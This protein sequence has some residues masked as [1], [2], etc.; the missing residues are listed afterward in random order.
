MNIEHIF[1][2]DSLT[3][4]ESLVMDSFHIRFIQSL[5]KGFMVLSFAT[6]QLLSARGDSTWGIKPNLE[7]VGFVDA[8][9]S[10][11]AFSEYQIPRQNFLYNHNR[12]NETTINLALAGM[13]VIHS[14][15]RANLMLQ[16]GTYVVDNYQTEPVG[17]R[18]LHEANV[19]VSLNKKNSLWFD[20]GVFSSHV[21][22]ESAI[23]VLNPTLTRSLTAEFS[24]YYLTGTR[25]TYHISDKLSLMG[26]MANGWQR[27]QR[28]EDETRPLLGSGLVFK[29]SE[30]TKINW[31]TLSGIVNRNGENHTRYFNNFFF[32]HEL[33]NQLSIF[34]VFDFGY[35][36][37]SRQQDLYRKWYGITAIARFRLRE[38]W[39]SSLR[40]E[41]FY[42]ETDQFV[43][44]IQSSPFL[45]HPNNYIHGYSVNVD[46]IPNEHVQCRVEIKHQQSKYPVYGPTPFTKNDCLVYTASIAI[47]IEQIVSDKRH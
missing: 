25:V 27:I 20:M 28:L 36:S 6:P 5:L 35:E 29:P 2:R 9:H 45:T 44:R 7:I 39:F 18:H 3:K 16:A 21:G 19:G 37:V 33:S 46:F 43:S 34:G 47:G 12:Q 13:R 17:L 31:S 11:D 4:K 40:Y 42:D 22:L 23:S 1:E 8:Y 30:K 24:P 15:Y 14:K 41:H 26:M 38:N 32:T 10:Y